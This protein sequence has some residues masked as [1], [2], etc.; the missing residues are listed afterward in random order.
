LVGHDAQLLPAAVGIVVNG[1]VPES[2]QLRRDQ[3]GNPDLQGE[4][5]RG[6]AEQPFP[7]DLERFLRQVSDVVDD[8]GGQSRNACAGEL[9][10]GGPA[11]LAAAALGLAA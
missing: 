7:E 9:L 2:L 11:Q 6:E 4:I 1:R 8:V 10:L 3:I 5:D